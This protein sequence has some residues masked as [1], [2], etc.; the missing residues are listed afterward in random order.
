MVK[1]EYKRK[2]FVQSDSRLHRT[3]KMLV[4]E[5]L[6]E[7]NTQ[8]VGSIKHAHEQGLSRKL[9]KWHACESCE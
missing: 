5:F 4:A 3:W 6:R 9:F 8:G 2:V 1:K 7:W